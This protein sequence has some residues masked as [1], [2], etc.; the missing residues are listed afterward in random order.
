MK[1]AESISAGRGPLAEGANPSRVSLCQALLA[2]GEKFGMA[3]LSTARTG[4][5]CKSAIAAA[6]TMPENLKLRYAGALLGRT[7][8][9]KKSLKSIRCFWPG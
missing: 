2:P 9:S 1:N 3:A 8:P 5:E 6:A 7:R 4:R